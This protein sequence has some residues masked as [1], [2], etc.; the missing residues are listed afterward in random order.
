MLGFFSPLSETNHIWNKRVFFR[1]LH[2]APGVFGSF[3]LTSYI[4]PSCSH[5]QILSL[6]GKINHFWNKNAFCKWFHL[7]PGVFGSCMLTCY[8]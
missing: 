7:V 2:V 4:E 8:T 5:F 1:W 6:L 3:M